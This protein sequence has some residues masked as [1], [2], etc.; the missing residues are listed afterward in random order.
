MRYRC[1]GDTPDFGPCQR[2][3]SAQSAHRLLPAH[4][5]NRRLCLGRAEFGE[6]PKDVVKGT[7]AF[8]SL[9]HAS[10]HPIPLPRRNSP[11]PVPPDKGSGTPCLHRHL[12]QFLCPSYCSRTSP[13]GFTTHTVPPIPPITTPRYTYWKDLRV[14]YFKLEVSTLQCK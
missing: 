7:S 6:I 4:H 11:P 2:E 1:S 5:H 12:L 8:I 3:S 14:V 13:Y 9:W 10:F